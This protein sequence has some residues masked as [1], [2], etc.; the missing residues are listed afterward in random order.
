MQNIFY[1]L[2][3][4]FKIHVNI[5]DHAFPMKT[6]PLQDKW[7]ANPI[8]KLFPFETKEKGKQYLNK[9]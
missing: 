7:R 5:T 2:K 6:T 8:Y 3:R 1:K 4:E 9:F